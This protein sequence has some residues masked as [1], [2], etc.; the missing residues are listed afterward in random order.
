MTD[1]NWSVSSPAATATIGSI[2]GHITDAKDQVASRLN[3]EHVAIASGATDVL[4][5]GNHKKG[6]ARVFYQA[7]APSYVPD[8][9][10]TDGEGA[11]ALTSVD[12]N[13]VVLGTGRIWIDSDTKV[14]YVYDGDSWESVQFGE[15]S[16]GGD[17]VLQSGRSGGQTIVGGTDAGDSLTLNSNSVDSAGDVIFDSNVR[18]VALN[19]NL[20]TGLKLGSHANANAK[21]FIGFP[22]AGTI[23]DS[24]G[25]GNA[26]IND[27]CILPDTGGITQTAFGSVACDTNDRTVDVGF[28]PDIIVGWNSNAG[29]YAVLYSA[30][31]SSIVKNLATG[32]PITNSGATQ[33]I[34][35]SGDVITFHVGTVNV[36]RTSVGTMFYIAIGTNYAAKNPG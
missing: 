22:A 33:E 2:P 19:D 30:S 29:L 31:D 8:S 17:V 24:L 15:A 28:E 14:I 13:S 20:V 35:V 1:R 11:L 6:S 27:T 3:I 32:A 34:S 7:N 4:I 5:G 9:S 12:T 23:G 16:A 10:T 36:N 21:R 18:Y 25:F 26:D